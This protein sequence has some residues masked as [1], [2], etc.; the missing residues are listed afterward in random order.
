MS[1]P[2]FPAQNATA[3]VSASTKAVMLAEFERAR[4]IC[5]KI[6]EGKVCA[7]VKFV[8]DPILTPELRT[9]AVNGVLD[10]SGGS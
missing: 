9:V 5:K 4:D 3:N 7:R 1:T 10:C 8:L 6:N 2:V